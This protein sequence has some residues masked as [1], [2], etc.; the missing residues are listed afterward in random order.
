MDEFR[1][2]CAECGFDSARWRVH[3][4][5]T[6]FAALA[7]WWRQATDGVDAEL[8]NR[9]PTPGVWSVLEYGVHVALVTAALRWSIEQ[10]FATDGVELPAFTTPDAASDDAPLV[11]E[12]AAVIG[13][14]DR[15][16]AALGEV[17]RGAGDGQWKHQARAQVELAADAIL[18]HA[19]H[20]ASH[21]CMDVARGLLAVGG[22]ARPQAGTVAQVN[23][24]TGGVPKLPVDVAAVD[25]D[26]VAGDVQADKRHHGRPFQALCLWSSDVLDELAS[27][28][29]P[30]GPGRAGENVTV[31]GIDWSAV[32]PGAVVRIGTVTA[33]LSFAAVPCAKQSQ[34]FSDGDFRRIAYEE[35]PQW[36]RWYAWVREP[37]EVRPGDAAVVQPS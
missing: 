10:A 36:V 20:D 34:W 22:G 25:H 30:I 5:G 26:G 35:N 1:E 19:A 8:L 11:L 2:T 3:D 23:S 13:D 21:H 24:S 33:E 17:I 16:C 29:H 14:I 28:G 18:F 15:E 32:R 4:A 37:G 6:F 27:L 9:R 31:R 7:E 12:R